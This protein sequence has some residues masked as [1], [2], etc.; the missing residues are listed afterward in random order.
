MAVLDI[1]NTGRVTIIRDFIYLLDHVEATW[2]YSV[3]SDLLS[4]RVSILCGHPST[5]HSDSLMLGY[6]IRLF[7]LS[8]RVVE[9]RAD[10]FRIAENGGLVFRLREEPITSEV[11]NWKEEGF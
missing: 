3:S 8:D 2:V 7:D 11:F 4:F 6:T 5:L 10:F 1:I 9:Y